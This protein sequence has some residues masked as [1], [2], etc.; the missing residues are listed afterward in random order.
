MKAQ[1]ESKNLEQEKLTEISK[2]LDMQLDE[3]CI[4]QTQKNIAMMANKLS[5]EETQTIY[6]YLGNTL[7]HFNGQ[8]VHVKAVLTKLL[9]ELLGAKIAGRI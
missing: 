1:V 8:P 7:E 3:Y 9:T 4:F 2:S 5:L 6:G